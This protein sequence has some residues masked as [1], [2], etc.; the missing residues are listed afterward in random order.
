MASIPKT[1]KSLAV[2]KYSEPSDYQLAYL[3]VPEIEKPNEVLV[4]VRAGALNTGSSM[5]VAGDM[6]IAYKPG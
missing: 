5:L 1:M 3:P 2:F 6:D 4:K